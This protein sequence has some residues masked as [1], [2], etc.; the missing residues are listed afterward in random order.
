[1]YP[2]ESEV[3][4]VE[5][6]APPEGFG[7]FWERDGEREVSSESGS[8]SD[9]DSSPSPET[10]S[11]LTLTLDFKLE[12]CGEPVSNLE[13]NSGS[14]PESELESANSRRG[15]LGS[16]SSPE[17]IE[18]DS[19]PSSSTRSSEDSSWSKTPFSS[20]SPTWSS[21]LYFSS[22]AVTVGKAVLE[23][24]VT[25]GSRV[26]WRSVTSSHA[27]PGKDLQLVRRFLIFPSAVFGSTA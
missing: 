14:D 5:V 20:S 2:T 4:D 19:Q 17:W 6:P 22:S 27:L 25:E 10:D 26:A 18:P 13:S 23:D 11:V 16:S 12:R 3:R 21:G 7:T 8:V 15:P 9:A 1:M 24:L